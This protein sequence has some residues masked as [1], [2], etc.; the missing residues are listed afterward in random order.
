MSRFS[1]RRTPA[2]GPE[3]R[4][5]VLPEAA[6]PAARPAAAPPGTAPAP[7]V[8]APVKSSFIV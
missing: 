2:A 7:S 8:S 5:L 6:A 1:F 3:A 4:D